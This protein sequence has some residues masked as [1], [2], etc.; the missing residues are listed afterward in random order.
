MAFALLD[1][2]GQPANIEVRSIRWTN[3][4]PIIEAKHLCDKGRRNR[5]GVPAFLLQES[6]RLH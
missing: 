1:Y 5:G 2:G 4:F 6:L 3:I